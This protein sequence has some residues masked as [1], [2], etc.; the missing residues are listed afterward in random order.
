MFKRVWNSP[1]LNTWASFFGRTLGAV[2]VLPLVL[3]NFPVEDFNVWSLFSTLLGLQLLVD[4]GFCVTFVRAIAFGLA[5]A[6]SAESFQK[7]SAVRG[8]GGP[9][10]QLIKTVVSVM[11]YIYQRTAL[12]YLILLSTLGTWALFRPIQLCS[13]PQQAWAAWTI[14]IGAGYLTLRA[15]YLAVLLQGLNEI[16]IVRR[17]EAI[18]SIG[19]VLTSFLVLLLGG[20][21]LVLVAATHVWTL[22]AIFRNHQLCLKAA[23]GKFAPLPISKS[24]PQMIK[25]LWPPTWRSGVGVLMS[26]GLIQSSAIITAQYATAANSASYMLCL[27]I[28][29]LI[30]SFSQAPFYSKMPLLPRLKAEGK[31]QELL[32]VASNGM[33]KSLW[34]YALGFAGASILGSFILSKI[35]S[36]VPFPEPVF[37]V[38]LGTMFFIERYAAM[39]LNLYSTTNH[40]ITHIA[41]GITGMIAII[42]TLLLLPVLGL[43]ALPTGLLIGYAGFYSWFPV[44]FSYREYK[45]PFWEFESKNSIAPLVLFAMSCAFLLLNN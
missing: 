31:I 21:L 11:R 4:M 3:K 10:W 5:G 16:A 41:N 17:W 6:E 12:L 9:N 22:V 43:L 40:I 1:T 34:T 37:W 8:S 20:N 19:S 23:N 29:Q 18:T 14:V 36:N 2:L 13:N 38:I 35:R 7:N 45:M 26:F 39:H 24:N 30:S 27:R 33:R 32:K 42:S 44:V 15:N 25:H 28:M